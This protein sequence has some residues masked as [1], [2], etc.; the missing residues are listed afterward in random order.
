MFVEKLVITACNNKTTADR[1]SDSGR[2]SSCFCYR[3]RKIFVYMNNIHFG[4]QRDKKYYQDI[5]NIDD[6]VSASECV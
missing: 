3:A 4:T 1:N 5:K 6:C 2:G